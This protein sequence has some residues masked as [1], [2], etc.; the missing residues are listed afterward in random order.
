MEHVLIDIKFETFITIL[1]IQIH[2]FCK[3]YKY[4]ANV[5]TEK[6]FKNLVNP[7]KFLL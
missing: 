7:D 1:K 2:N 4:Y 5:H 6:S 3:D